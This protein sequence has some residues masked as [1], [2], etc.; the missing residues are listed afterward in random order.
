MSI[1]YLCSLRNIAL[2]VS[3]GAFMSV[4]LP[5]Q[6]EISKVYLLKKTYPHVEIMIQKQK[7]EYYLT[8]LILV[9]HIL[10]PGVLLFK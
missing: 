4:N 5:L 10:K 8:F 6:K 7:V 1:Q 9:F 2:T 3:G